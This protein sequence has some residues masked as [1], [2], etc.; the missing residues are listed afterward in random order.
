MQAIYE[1]L[2]EKP[3][4]RK[5]KDELQES[6][7]FN[8]L[9]RREL[10]TVLHYAL[11]RTFKK[12]DHIF[13]EGDP[14]SALFIVLKGSVHIVK[15]EKNKLRHIAK[16]GKGTFFG[17]IALVYDTIRSATAIVSED[18]MMACLFKHDLEQIMKEHPKLAGKL[19]H[20]ISKILAQR[21]ATMVE[22]AQ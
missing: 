6:L 1:Y 2:F 4:I 15:H 14:G 16:L 5:M 8:S 9:T 19:L 13:F 11:L 12:G 22:K 21:L 7:L 10:D 17:E 3:D 18:A 20:S